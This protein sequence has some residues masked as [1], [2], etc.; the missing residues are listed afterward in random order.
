MPFEKK[1]AE[2]PLEKE[3]FPFI[4]ELREVAGWDGR[5]AAGFRSMVRR[6]A[7]ANPTL[8]RT[9]PGFDAEAAIEA[10][11]ARAEAEGAS[12]ATVRGTVTQLRQLLREAAEREKSPRAWRGRWR[13]KRKRRERA[14]AEAASSDLPIG[15]AAGAAGGAGGE[16]APAVAAAADSPDSTGWIDF[17]FPLRPGVVL[18]LRL[19]ADLSA[20]EGERLALFVRS[21]GR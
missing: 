7:Q 14:T 12:P 9:S 10:C 17:P 6:L 20:E 15:A 21:L 3:L 8:S 19:P 2:L 13:R 18:N 16:L 4:E 11:R 1:D 5:R